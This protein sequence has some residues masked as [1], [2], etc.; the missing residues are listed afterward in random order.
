MTPLDSPAA[1]IAISVCNA[2]K[3]YRLFSHPADRVRQFFSLGL[4]QYHRGFTALSDVSFDIRKG[5]SVGIIG[6]NGSGKSTLL[7]LICGILK[8]TSGKVQVRGRVSALL[9]LGA[10]FNPEFTGRENVYFYGALMGFDRE[11]VASRFTD[12]ARFADIGE[13]LDLPTRTYSS[14]MFV[15]LAFAVAVHFDPEILIVD[16]A[17]AVGDL[18]FQRKCFNKL[19]ELRARKDF[20]LLFVSHDLRQIE[21]LSTRVICLEKGR[22]V[23]DGP[24][25]RVCRY[26]Y[27][28]LSRT[29]ESDARGVLT[30]DAHYI[31]LLDV[32]VLDQDGNSVKHINSGHALRVRIRFQALTSLDGVELIVGT[33]AANLQYLSSS[34]TREAGLQLTFPPGSY[35]IEYLVDHFPVVAGQYFIRFAVRGR[36][37]ELLYS[38]EGLCPFDV[39]SVRA[40][41]NRPMGLLDLK[42][43]WRIEDQHRNDLP[44]A[45]I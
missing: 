43:E 41:F 28:T 3:T 35:S 24:P 5:E 12:I 27:E 8:P 25:E 36:A 14:G 29:G 6:R 7:Q 31:K 9:E 2:G 4:K 44:N 32:A 45:Q 23:M 38:C 42:T 34:S 22:L 10:G 19:E 20:N 18:A 37:F 1:E 15:R 30:A 40:D 33:Q 17:L 16:E 21:R 11:Q 13:H 26:Y 39:L